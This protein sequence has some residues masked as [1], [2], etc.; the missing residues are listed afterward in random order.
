V[1][2]AA[3][4]VLV[5][6]G[7]GALVLPQSS[8][9]AL[10]KPGVLVSKKLLLSAEQVA[11]LAGKQAWQLTGT[12]N[13]TEGT[14]KNTMCQAAR[15]AD[16]NGL[17]TWVRTFATPSPARGPARG[18][19]QTVEISD[20][21]GAAKKAFDTTLGWYA[22]CTTPRIQLVDAYVVHGVGEEAQI[23]RM[24]IPDQQP[25][26]FLVG[27]ARTGSLTTSTVLETHTPG[28]A[29]AALMVNA[30]TASV[31]DLCSSRVAGQCVGPVTAEASL[32]PASGEAPG[33]LAIADQPAVADVVQPWAG[34]DPAPAKVNLA[35]TTCD[36]ADFVKA[37]V[38]DAATRTYLIPNA[39][40]PERFG[41]SE[42]L[43]RFPSAQS[44]TAF[45]TRIADR[46]K[47]C[48]DREL[49]SK[50]THSVV[51]LKARGSASYAL[52]RLENQV[53]QQED[54][55]PFWMGVVQLGREVAQVNLTP[56]GKYDVDAKTFE[57]LVVRA[58]D[59]LHEVGQ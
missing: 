7:A 32:P 9:K 11:P 45:V 22:G 17:G 2:G 27:V 35:A 1:L 33:M 15:F 5:T 34:T 56:V 6:I 42:T 10:P 36:K 55:I 58:R 57:A 43:G 37:G 53:N 50:V 8:G 3:L 19:V 18:L 26:S 28:P 46:M 51:H 30:L 49:A 4:A 13:N 41:L 24:R 20:S 12:S 39:G 47:T 21:P 54:V 25:R 40:L 31:Q 48:P 44:A 29:D 23:L 38:S 59:R 16:A 52:W 14:G